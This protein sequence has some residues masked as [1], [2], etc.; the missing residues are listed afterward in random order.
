MSER[1]YE[2]TIEAPD[3][4]EDLFS[5][6]DREDLEALNAQAPT[7]HP[8]LKIW[9]EVL[10]HAE[11]E[12]GA[13]VTPQWANRI[14]SSY[15]ELNYADMPDF[16][17]RFFGKLV[18]LVKILEVEIATDDE[19]LTYTSPEEDVE[20]NSRHYHNVLRA[21]QVELM[22]WELDWDCTSEHAATEIAAISEV[23]KQLFGPTG[24]TQFLDN[25]KFE[26][27]EADQ[28]ET[29]AALEALKEGR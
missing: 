20:F 14:T 23:H 6:Q 7:F 25:I 11:G 19:C 9:H 24:I 4:V 10:H 15:R 26:V 1:E 13:K 18:D 29:V 2:E 28:A 5:E 17:D 16:R 8:I 27:T 12:L 3:N 21:W 22:R